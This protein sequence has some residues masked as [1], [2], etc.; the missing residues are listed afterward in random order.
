MRERYRTPHVSTG[1]MLRTAIAA[2][3]PLGRT[4]RA[5]VDAGQLVPDDMMAGLVRDRL[6][7]SDA[8]GGFILDGFPRTVEQAE[9]LGRLLDSMGRE[10][11]HVLLLG[12]E[13]AEVV[14][15]LSGRRSCASCGAPYHVIAAPSR[16][17]GRCDRCAPPGGTLVQRPDDR[18]DVVAERL[19]VYHERTAP[20][21]DH[22]RRRGL[23][24]EVDASGSVEDVERRILVTLAGPAGAAKAAPRRAGGDRA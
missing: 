7:E 3:T 19:R 10:L 20:L 22:Y 16:V 18:E 15:R 1:D 4:A 13:D 23:L 17:E 6:Q 5:L 9:I 8:A 24:R 12:L 2:G 11:D 14:R 21:A